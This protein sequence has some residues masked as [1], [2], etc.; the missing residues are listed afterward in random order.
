M[1][2]A[3]CSLHINEWYSNIVKYAIENQRQYCELHGYDFHTPNEVYDGKRKIMWYKIQAILKILDDYD[4]VVWFDA[5][6]F[7][8]K[9]EDTIEKLM[10]KWMA[11]T[12]DIFCGRDHN[13]VLNTGIMIIKN[14]EF[15]KDI[16]RKVW[17]RVPKEQ[18]FH[19]Q[20]ALSELY[21]ENYNGAK[22]KISILPIHEK[23][24]LY[25]FWAE[26]YPNTSF[27]VHAARCAQDPAGFMYTLDTYC[28]IKMDEETDKVYRDRIDWLSNPQR[29]R[30]SIERWIRNDYR[31]KRESLRSIRYRE[32]LRYNNVAYEHP[33]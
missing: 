7:I 26:Y 4:V 9:K 15:S 32:Y 12:T 8:M 30:D 11:E 22:E 31:D 16:L 18:N 14:T 33:Y 6:G 28:P 2:I 29:C 3:V 27:F 10:E 13:N 17:D 19:E 1:K 23:V 24:K 21:L 25:C 20:A 5:D